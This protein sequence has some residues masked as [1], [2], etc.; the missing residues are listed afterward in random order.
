MLGFKKF[1][2]LDEAMLSDK[3]HV[4]PQIATLKA[5]ATANKDGLARFTHDPES[6]NTMAADAHN[7]THDD[8]SPGAKVTGYIYHNKG[9]H[10]YAAFVRDTT[11]P[12]EGL[13]TQRFEKYGMK[14]EKHPFDLSNGWS[15]NKKYMTPGEGERVCF[16]GGFYGKYYNKPKRKKKVKVVKADFGD[17]K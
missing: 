2:E 15:G 7:S 3:I 14:R 1:I 5:L 10:T 6:N 4:N 11:T 9:K 13:I 16:G 8:I 12:Y 17:Y